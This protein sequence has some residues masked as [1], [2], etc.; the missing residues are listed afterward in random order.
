MSAAEIIDAAVAA[1]I[2]LAERGVHLSVTPAH[3]LT[4]EMRAELVSNRSAVL[5]LLRK[6][7][8][9][10]VPPSRSSCDLHEEPP[11]TQVWIIALVGGGRVTAVNTTGA[12][13][14][15]MLAIARDQ[16]GATRV[17]GV[18]LRC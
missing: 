7:S 6:I 14:A 13:V 17:V 5:D 8:A 18:E 11:R 16:F 12:D 9:Q 1:G 10:A 2:T 15:E 3:L 4:P